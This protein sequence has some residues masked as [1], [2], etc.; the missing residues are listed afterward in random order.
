VFHS[1]SFA[2]SVTLSTLLLLTLFSSPVMA[3]N[4][5]A[6]RPS[7]TG[8]AGPPFAPKADD[9]TSHR[10]NNRGYPK[11][12]K[13]GQ[14]TLT[15]DNSYGAAGVIWLK[16]SIELPFKVEFEYSIFDDDGGV[17]NNSA[18]GIVFMFCKNKN[19]YKNHPNGGTRGFIKDDTGYGLDLKTYSGEEIRLINGRGDVMKSMS[20]Y[21]FPPSTGQRIY[22]HGQWKKVSLLITKKGVT[23]GF[24]GKTLFHHKMTIDARHRGIGFGAA[25]GGSDSAH[26]LRNI[27]LLPL[28]PIPTTKKSITQFLNCLELANPDRIQIQN[29]IDDMG[30]VDFDRRKKA[31]QQLFHRA[32]L[33]LDLIDRAGRSE[34]LDIRFRARYILAFGE[35]VNTKTINIKRV[36]R[37]IAL[38]KLKGLRE[39]LSKLLEQESMKPHSSLI[40][41]ALTAT[42]RVGDKQWLRARLKTSAHSNFYQQILKDFKKK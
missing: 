12:G 18:D 4:E 28:C 35:G 26:H 1:K 22:T 15:P 24:A 3:Q 6:K 31:A 13:K 11:F 34:D 23:V 41:K 33:P 17:D 16:K 19:D 21:L 32:V 36:L 20:S 5:A 2:P 42:L 30:H 39:P 14:V 25:T 37:T 29:W 38:S 7:Q 8:S 9:F 27:Q 10:T 40:E